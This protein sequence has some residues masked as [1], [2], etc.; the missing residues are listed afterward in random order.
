M[1][2]QIKCFARE[3]E[4]LP[5][6]RFGTTS[7]DASSGYGKSVLLDFASACFLERRRMKTRLWNN[8]RLRLE[9]RFLFVFASFVSCFEHWSSLRILS[10]HTFPESDLRLSLGGLDGED[11]WSI[12]QFFLKERKW[13]IVEENL[14]M[15]MVGLK[16]NTRLCETCVL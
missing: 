14:T 16:L 6:L 7:V 13:E 1:L 5:S 3:T 9:C 12:F 11:I 4:G 15:K 2:W 10:R 8:I